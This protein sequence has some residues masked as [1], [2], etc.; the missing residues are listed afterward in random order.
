MREGNRR[1]ERWCLW[2]ILQSEQHTSKMALFVG[3]DRIGKGCN[4]GGFAVVAPMPEAEEGWEE[5]GDDEDG[6]K[7]D[8]GGGEG[9]GRHA[10]VA[11]EEVH[12]FR[13][14]VTICKKMFKYFSRVAVNA[15]TLPPNLVIGLYL[16]KAE[17]LHIQAS[18]FIQI[19]ILR[20]SVL[21][22]NMQASRLII[23]H[24]LCTP[25][26]IKVVLLAKICGNTYAIG[27]LF[28]LTPRNFFFSWTDPLIAPHG[29]KNVSKVKKN[30]SLNI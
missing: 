10:D 27:I 3:K 23:V 11:L 21:E 28:A 5:A 18:W 14:W 20:R 12:C 19:P 29:I 1:L 30:K 26:V 15:N 7:D 9:R 22:R 16:V 6:Q 4:E 24:M 8:E 13:N 17:D 25:P 2:V